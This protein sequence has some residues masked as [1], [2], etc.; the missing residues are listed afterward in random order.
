MQWEF[1]P[2]RRPFRQP[3]NTHHGEWRDR[4]GIILRLTT[5]LGQVGYGEVAP[6]P[7]FGSETL[8][9]ALEFCQQLPLHLTAD[10][11]HAIPAT[12]PACQF[13]FESAWNTVEAGDCPLS[14]PL[15]F[16]GLLP[17]GQAALTAWKPL[18]QQGYRTFKWKI[19]VG[20][21]QDELQLLTQ[22]VALL[23]PD[24]RLRL[25]ANGGLTYN[26]AQCWLDQCDTSQIEFLEQPLSPAQ[27]ALM[28]ELAANSVTPIALDESIA[29]L[30]HL[31]ACHHDGWRGIYVIKP[32]IVGSPAQLRQ[33][34]QQHA[35]DA[36]FSSVFETAIGRQ[37]GLQL[38]AELGNRDRAMGYGITHWFNHADLEADL[39]WQT[40]SPI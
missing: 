13:G 39:L 19:S 31:Q 9:Q 8:E 12:L 2:Y 7:W 30:A 26:Q 14:Y 3:I 18:W 35:I 17:A 24:C 29:T 34:C 10:L 1:R 6:L 22:L 36:V 32:A 15:T 21:L 27:L 20:D 16:S 28:Q 40:L 38:A 11:I 4:T 25:D 23:P 37:A 33:F 5:D